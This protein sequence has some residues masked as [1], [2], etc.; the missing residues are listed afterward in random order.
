MAQ[1]ERIGAAI[2]WRQS[3]EGK[4]EKV[5]SGDNTEGSEDGSGESQK[6]GTPSSAS[7]QY[8]GF[9]FFYLIEF[10]IFCE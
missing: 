6:E 9:L 10:F 5:E 8:S 3:L 1:L 4:V 7:C 2:E